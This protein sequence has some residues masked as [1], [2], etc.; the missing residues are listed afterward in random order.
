[1]FPYPLINQIN[2]D[3]V[4][5]VANS[6]FEI[7]CYSFQSCVWCNDLEI[8]N[9]GTAVTQSSLATT[10]CVFYPEI[11]PPSEFKM[12]AILFEKTDL[13][14]STGSLRT[15]KMNVICT[16]NIQQQY[17]I[18]INAILDRLQIFFLPQGFY[19]HLGSYFTKSTLDPINNPPK[20]FLQILHT[21]LPILLKPFT[22]SSTLV[23]RTPRRPPTSPT[24]YARTSSASTFHPAPMPIPTYSNEMIDQL[25]ALYWNQLLI[26]HR[27]SAL[28]S[29]VY[30]VKPYTF[31]NDC[32]GALPNLATA[33]AS[34]TELQKI[35][36]PS[37]IAAN[38]LEESLTNFDRL[39]LPIAIDNH[40]ILFVRNIYIK[41]S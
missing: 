35:Y 33:I 12:F 6:G 36:L 13:F 11:Q 7:V 39:I 5:I 41:K 28:A 38:Y 4:N 22:T 1:M 27:P 20:D 3:I 37:K 25:C 8:D 31:Y 21:S 34:S 2:Q 15:I 24:P 16:A 19:R 9:I 30:P 17:Q 10:L 18:L 40:L 32:R 23:M 26:T 29:V 14:T